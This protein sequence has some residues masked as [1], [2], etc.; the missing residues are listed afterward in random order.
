M[1]DGS[2]ERTVVGCA[3]DSRGPWLE[4]GTAFSLAT[5]SGLGLIGS[6]GYWAARLA[7]APRPRAVVQAVL[8]AAV[9]G[10]LIAAKALLH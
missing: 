5:W 4:L 2:V 9:G 1:P 10:V 6:Y 8:V 3:C 7:G